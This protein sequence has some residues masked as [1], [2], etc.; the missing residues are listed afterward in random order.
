MAPNRPI[1][2][3]ET[4]VEIDEQVGL[5]AAAVAGQDGGHGVAWGRPLDV[6]ELAADRLDP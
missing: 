3:A 2:S 1:N 4:P 6:G 5:E